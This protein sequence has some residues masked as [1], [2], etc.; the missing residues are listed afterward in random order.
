MKIAMMFPGY[1]SQ[2]V[3]MSKEL[4]DQNR[5][6]QELFDQASSCLDINFVKLCF[7]SS[8]AELS[9]MRHAYTAIFLVSSAIAAV[10]AE[11]S[12]KPDAVAGFN[13]GVYAALFAAQSLS[14]PDGLYLLNKLAF[15]YQQNLD[16]NNFVA[17]LIEGLTSKELQSVCEL[18]Q[19]NG[20][21][22]YIAVYETEKR[23]IVIGHKKAIELVQDKASEFS[24][25]REIS[26]EYADLA[27]GL[28]SELA[29]PIIDEFK[30]YLH[31]VDFHNLSTPLIIH[32]GKELTQGADVAE[33]IV[34]RIEC[35]VMWPSIMKRLSEYDCVIAIGPGKN[36]ER[37]FKEVYPDTYIITVNRPEDIEA[38]VSYIE[39]TKKISSELENK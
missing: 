31:K 20:E 14:L 24:S 16:Q 3:G 25:Q 5:L 32:S 29:K 38:V 22:A 26:I 39:Q 27:V 36:L 11:K 15:F 17:L 13:H 30:V 8:E 9:T 33:Y 21:R 19:K 4:Y 1:G 28:H 35:P 10:L 2:F 6:V 12:I 23:H 18:A 7:A 34:D 37:W